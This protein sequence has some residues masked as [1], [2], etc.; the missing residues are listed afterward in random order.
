VCQ[1]QR[2]AEEEAWAVEHAEEYAA[3]SDLDDDDD[4]H[5]HGHH[6]GG[7]AEHA[8][9]SPMG[10][11]GTLHGG[12]LPRSEGSASLASPSVFAK[13]SYSS[14]SSLSAEAAA[15]AS[16]G[17]E[18]L[19]AFGDS[20]SVLGPSAQPDGGGSAPGISGE[21]IPGSGSTPALGQL[22]RVSSLDSGDSAVLSA[23]LASPV[24]EP[25]AA[26]VAA[27][28]LCPGLEST[29]SRALLKAPSSLLPRNAAFPL[30]RDAWHP[31]ISSTAFQPD[32]DHEE[33]NVTDAETHGGCGSG[34]SPHLPSNSLSAHSFGRP[35]T[36]GSPN[37]WDHRAED[38]AAA[39]KQ[40]QQKKKNLADPFRKKKAPAID[41][42][43]TVTL[44][45][46]LR[47]ASAGTR[48]ANACACVCAQHSTL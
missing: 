44:N 39:K 20:A 37:S 34:E 32:S 33:L 30:G 1:V 4:H 8:M 28:R 21:G 13:S 3:T 11:P 6:G 31:D 48:V 18:L 46:P 17:A 40:Q 12:A 45:P 27:A 10:K 26:A 2:I 14:S 22:V 35:G 47:K 24:T 23:A 25:A 9:S 16:K 5:H 38:A 41:R 29:L 19:A 15:A 43:L 7:G 36:P 42:A